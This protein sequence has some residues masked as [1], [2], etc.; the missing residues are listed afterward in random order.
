MVSSLCCEKWP[1]ERNVST[2]NLQTIVDRKENNKE[3]FKEDDWTLLPCDDD[4]T[5]GESCVSIN[6]G[7]NNVHEIKQSIIVDEEN[8]NY[9]LIGG[10]F[11]GQ[12]NELSRNG[13]QRPYRTRR[14]LV[15][16]SRLKNPGRLKDQRP[17]TILKQSKRSKVLN[18]ETKQAKNRSKISTDFCLRNN[19]KI[20]KNCSFPSVDRS[21]SKNKK[22]FSDS[23]VNK[24]V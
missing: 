24:Q 6:E 23:G 4:G 19:P 5:S 21:L 22:I 13:F 9:V 12:L 1:I 14:T 10:S 8:K 18:Q 16:R 3:I 20:N 2:L 17:F 7:F 15:I 11:S